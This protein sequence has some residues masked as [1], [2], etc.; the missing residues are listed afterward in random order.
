MVEWAMRVPIF[1][2]ALTTAEHAALVTAL[3]SSNAFALR[4]AQILLASNQRA[5]PAQIAATYGCSDQTVRNVIREFQA[6]GLQVLKQGSTART[7]QLP[8]LDGPKLEVLRELLHRSPRDFDKQSSLW[9]LALAAT[10]AYEQGLTPYVVS[11]E[12]IRNALKRLQVSWQRA[13]HWIISPDPRYETKKTIALADRI[14]A[15]A[16]LGSWLPR[17]VLVE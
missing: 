7:D 10:V 14:S 16:G 4:R 11:I 2:P 8:L 1:V 17:R 12:T 15:K 3:R 9:S 13:K 5:K 6:R